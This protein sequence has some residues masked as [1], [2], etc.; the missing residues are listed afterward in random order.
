V[1]VVADPPNADKLPA[2]ARASYPDMESI[3][4]PADEQEAMI[5]GAQENRR[6]Q[7]SPAM[8]GTEA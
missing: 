6:V 2:D 8:A 5:R 7:A 1:L 4:L 3:D